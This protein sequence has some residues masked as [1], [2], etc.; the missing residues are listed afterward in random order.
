MEETI[1]K[2]MKNLD[3]SREE[4][5]ALIEDD[6]AIDK[7]EKLFELTAE[8]K[9]AAKAATKADSKP[10]STPTKREKASDSVKLGLIELFTEVLKEQPMCNFVEIVNPER[11]F[12][13]V[14]AGKKYKV[15]LSCP[16]K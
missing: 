13:F 10:R 5:I 11:E 15:T 3:L 16:R 9:K 14:W 12:L 1:S 7:G 2:L 8:Q 6:K 4:A